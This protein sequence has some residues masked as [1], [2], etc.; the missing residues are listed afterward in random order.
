MTAPEPRQV[1]TAADAK[2]LIE[3]RDLSHVKVG[4]FDI[5]GILRGKYM[6]ALSHNL[7][8]YCA[9]FYHPMAEGIA[10][11][12]MS[13]FLCWLRSFCID[14]TMPVG[15]WVMRWR[16]RSPAIA[17]RRGNAIPGRGQ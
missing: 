8:A 4:V 12:G 14:T 16:G 7:E 9:P 5:D 6:D 17:H 2:A 1:R 3:Q 13:R 11:E 15:R 10:I